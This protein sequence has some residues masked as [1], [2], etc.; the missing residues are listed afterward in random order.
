M[1]R[2]VPLK[3]QALVLRY[4]ELVGVKTPVEARALGDRDAIE[5]TVAPAQPWDV[6]RWRRDG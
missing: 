6:A 1:V 5:A 3:A 2:R 4:L